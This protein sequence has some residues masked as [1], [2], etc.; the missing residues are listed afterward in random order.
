MN[1][2][3]L[4]LRNNQQTGPFTIGELLQQQLKSSDMIWVEGKS[5]AWTYVSE[6]ELIPFSKSAKPSQESSTPGGDEIEN[7]AEELRRRILAST[8]KTYFP[9]HTPEIERYAS[10]Y[11]PGENIEFIDHRKEKKLYH[12]A[13]IGEALLTCFVAGLFVVGFYKGKSLLASKNQLPDTVA[14]QLHSNSE[15]T[16]AQ[17]KKLLPSPLVVIDSSLVNDSTVGITYKPKSSFVKKNQLDSNAIR[18][19]SAEVNTLVQITDEE[20]KEEPQ[21]QTIKP[22]LKIP[23]EIP[24]KKEVSNAVRETGNRTEAKEEEKKGFLKG[25]FKKKKKDD[26]SQTAEDNGQ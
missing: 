9:K 10:P 20:K 24:L 23:E 11:K 14:I 4:V 13:V 1:K 3:Y 5:T 21:S 7:K 18:S 26:N 6:L 19:S 12:S 15:H 2:V 17:N 25:I 22:V 16:A 8:P